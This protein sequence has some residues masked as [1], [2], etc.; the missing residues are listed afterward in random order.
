M[1]R[2]LADFSAWNDWVQAAL[3]SD[4]RLAP[5]FPEARAIKDFRYNAWYD[6]IVRRTSSRRITA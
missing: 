2:V 1:Q 6:R 3:F 4:R 5:T